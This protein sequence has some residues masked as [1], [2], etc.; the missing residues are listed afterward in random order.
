MRSKDVKDAEEAADKAI[1]DSLK[2]SAEMP[3]LEHSREVKETVSLLNVMK[4]NQE[5]QRQKLE[6]QN[7][8]KVQDAK[9][10]ALAQMIFDI[11]K[12]T[13]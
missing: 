5:L 13:L 9:N 1:E 12:K 7:Y 4:M 10:K 8:I 11:N 2:E 3:T 6:L